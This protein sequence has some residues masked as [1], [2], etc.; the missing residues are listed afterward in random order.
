MATQYVNNETPNGAAMAA[1]LSAGVGVFAIGFI[2]ILNSLGWI[3]V[4][5]LYG[6]AG[7]VSGRTTLAVLVWLAVWGTLHSRWRHRHLNSQLI[8][9]TCLI[10]VGFGLLFTF[11]PLWDLL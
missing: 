3:S 10:L 4:P 8:L 9:I 1:L 11:P 5:A 2:V 6:P 7:G